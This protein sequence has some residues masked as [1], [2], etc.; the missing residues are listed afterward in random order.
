MAV[1]YFILLRSRA[2]SIP[3]LAAIPPRPARVRASSD[4]PTRLTIS[5]PSFLVSWVF[6]FGL[7]DRLCDL[8][9]RDRL[10]IGLPQLLD[11]EAAKFIPV[12]V[13]NAVSTRR[14]SLQVA[15]VPERLQ[16]VI[17]RLDAVGASAS[18]SRKCSDASISSWR[19]ASRPVMTWGS[20][21]YLLG[22][23]SN[24][25]IFIATASPRPQIR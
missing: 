4:F 23:A 19:F 20:A 3:D 11:A 2:C 18:C 6:A 13:D 22:P 25:A 12:E 24:D 1:R 7:D 21:I 15:L 9:R 16:N 5:L 10:S 17:N 8:A 14:H